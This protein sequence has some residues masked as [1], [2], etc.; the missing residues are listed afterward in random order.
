ML[1]LIKKSILT[2]S[3]Y[4][5]STSEPCL[6]SSVTNDKAI[7]TAASNASKLIDSYVQL[8]RMTKAS[9][10]RSYS[11]SFVIILLFRAVCFQSIH[12]YLSPDTYSRIT[13]AI[14]LYFMLKAWI[15]STQLLTTTQYY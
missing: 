10:L 3:I 7:S 11:N 5:N 4:K 1:Q 13:N 9:V 14:L 15:E 6:I 12:E 8:L 2:T